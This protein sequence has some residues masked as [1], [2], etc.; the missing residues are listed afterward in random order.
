MNSR[1]T[2]H[3]RNAGNGH[4]DVRGCNQHEVREFVDDDNHVAELFGNDNVIFARHHYLFIKFHC[5]T[6]RSGFDLFPFHHQG[7]LRLGLHD[8]LVLRAFVKRFN[9]AHADF[10]KNLVALFHFVNDP[11]Q[12]ENYLFGIGHNR[13]HEMRQRIVLL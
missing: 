10:C 8:R 1:G 4:F 13:N 2:G 12:R 3:L 5:E 11:A 7:Q 9:V 6:F